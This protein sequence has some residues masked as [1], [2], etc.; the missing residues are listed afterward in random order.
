MSKE[1]HK[2][3][4]TWRALGGQ[5]LITLATHVEKELVRELLA[6]GFEH[7]DVY[8]RDPADPVSGREIHLE[9]AARGDIQSITFAFDKYRRPAFQIHIQQ[10]NAGAPGDFV[11]AANLVRRPHQHLYFWGKPWWLP[12]RF[13][14]DRMSRR[15]VAYLVGKL[16]QALAFLDDGH[17]GPNISRSTDSITAKPE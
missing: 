1:R 2:R 16:D 17:R 15:T 13:W 10:R 6:V 8:M 3:H 9:R 14:S 12:A 4:A 11:R 5:P 7:A